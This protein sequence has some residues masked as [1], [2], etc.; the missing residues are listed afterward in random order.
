MVTGN[1]QRLRFLSNNYS[2][3]RQRAKDCFIHVLIWF[4]DKSSLGQRMIL[5]VVINKDI[6]IFKQTKKFHHL[7]TSSGSSLLQAAVLLH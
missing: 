1:V 5:I 6:G 3:P 7:M 2:F 4:L